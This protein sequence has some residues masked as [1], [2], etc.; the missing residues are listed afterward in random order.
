MGIQLWLNLAAEHKMCEPEYQEFKSKDIPCVECAE[1]WVKVISGEYADAKGVIKARTPTHY[2]DV[3]LKQEGASFE[4][5]VRKGWN[6][7]IVCYE[8]S[9]LVNGKSLSSIL[10]VAFKRNEA[11]DE[12]IKISAGSS[13]AKFVFI[14]GQPLEQ[15]VAWK[16]PF[17]MNTEE[18][19]KQTF[20][21]FWEAKNGFEG[22]K[23]WRSKNRD[24]K[25]QK[26]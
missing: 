21:D 11:A 17:V 24:L 9:L 6:A 1:S 13:E 22:A 2:F 12:V 10:A 23:E 19:I 8:G 15:P 7:M 25:Y 18:Q 26:K 3:H 5:V 4:H 14:S 16:G 20:E